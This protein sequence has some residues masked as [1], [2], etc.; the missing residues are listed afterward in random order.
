[1]PQSNL[2]NPWS[3][4]EDKALRAWVKS[5]PRTAKEVR[6]SLKQLPVTRNHT[7]L[8]IKTHILNL[9]R[10]GTLGVGI[11]DTFWNAFLDVCRALSKVSEARSLQLEEEAKPFTTLEEALKLAKERVPSVTWSSKEMIRRIRE[12]NSKHRHAKVR[13]HTRE[14]VL[15]AVSRNQF[16]RYLEFIKELPLIATD[17]SFVPAP[18]PTSQK[19]TGAPLVISTKEEATAIKSVVDTLIATGNILEIVPDVLTTIQKINEKKLEDLRHQVESRILGTRFLARVLYQVSAKLGI[20]IQDYD[21][22]SLSLSD[23]NTVLKFLD[24]IGA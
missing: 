6:I 1:M 21:S 5:S 10:N 18:V 14:D 4:Q 9:D 12:Y 7:I 22:G 19:I 24:E 15:S 2:K 23:C 13:Y 16:I 20:P 8:A 3:D 17:P 11:D